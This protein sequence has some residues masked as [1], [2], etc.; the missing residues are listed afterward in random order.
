MRW[1]QD[2]DLLVPGAL[3]L[4]AATLG[5]TARR[6]WQRWQR[7][8]RWHWLGLHLTGISTSYI[9]RLTAFYLDNGK[10]L[11]VWQTL[12]HLADWLLPS[13]AG[14]PLV[15]R[16]LARHRGAGSSIATGTPDRSWALALA[17]LATAGRDRMGRPGRCGGL[18]REHPRSG[19]CQGCSEVP[20]RTHP[21]GMVPPGSLAGG[22]RGGA[23]RTRGQ[24]C[25][26]PG[27]WAV[28]G[29]G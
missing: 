15:A 26:A 5:R 19:S 17:P 25:E 3:S 20:F 2:A 13:A 10:H 22:L 29:A 23:A 18:G 28:D 9:L 14:L 6:R 11:P 12:P 4:A 27:A 16:A 24:R 1:P 21:R 7:W 8:Q